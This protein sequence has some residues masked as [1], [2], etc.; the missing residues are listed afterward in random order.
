MKTARI[1]YVVFLTLSFSLLL[2]C[3]GSGDDIQGL[4]VEAKTPG[5]HQVGTATLNLVTPDVEFE[6][7]MIP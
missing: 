7:E 6:K 4:T 3:S 2:G 5:P 1:F